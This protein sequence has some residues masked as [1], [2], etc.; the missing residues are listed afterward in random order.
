VSGEDLLMHTRVVLVDDH[1]EFSHLMRA[2][3]GRQADLEVVAQ[4]GSLAEARS[5]A[6]SVRCDVAVLDLGLPD[7]NGAD[8]IADRREA[9]PDVAVVVLLHGTQK[10]Q[11]VLVHLIEH[12]L[13]QNLS[14]RAYTEAER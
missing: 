6:V 4:A 14:E 1:A 2:L 7:G 10:G 13:P 11:G 8:L 3:L 5:H 12:V 9:N